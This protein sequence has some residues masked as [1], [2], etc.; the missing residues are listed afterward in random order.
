MREIY[1]RFVECE[2]YDVPREKDP[3]WDPIEPIPIGFANAFLSPLAY[4]I[5]Y[6][7]MIEVKDFKVSRVSMPALLFEGG[8]II[9]GRFLTWNRL[10]AVTQ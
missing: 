5:E 1:Q 8:K 4:L 3:Y 9:H 2:D 10:S 7:N 6:N